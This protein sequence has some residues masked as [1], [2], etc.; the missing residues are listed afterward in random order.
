MGA[1]GDVVL[2]ERLRIVLACELPIP[3]EES[4]AQI[5]RAHSFEVHGEEG[6]VGEDI[7]VTEP[8]VELDAV[9]NAWTVVQAED[10]VG[11]QVAMT[12]SHLAMSDAI[13][14]ERAASVEV[15]P[16]QTAR[17]GRRHPRRGSSRRTVASSRSSTPSWRG[18]VDGGGRCDHRR[19]IGARMKGRDVASDVSQTV[20]DRLTATD[21][22][23]EP[24]LIGHA[25]HHDQVVARQSVDTEHLGDAEID[26]GSEA[27]VELDL[28]VTDRARVQPRSRSR[29]SR[30]SPASS[31]CRP[32]HRRRTRS[33]CASPARPLGQ[34]H[35]YRT[36]RS[37]PTTH[38][39]PHV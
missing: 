2:R 23:R 29:E 14:E 5:G 37:V 22:R 4:F 38:T 6:D 8:V 26:V 24:A 39:E 35:R 33:R 7:A 1:V 11:E 16:A 20:V 3:R 28:P 36:R 30:A 32:D 15:E 34:P 31:A 21:E 10:V 27:P 18:R 17:R 12:V 19:C 9:E 13:G 25:P